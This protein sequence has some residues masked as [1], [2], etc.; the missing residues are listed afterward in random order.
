MADH[1][2]HLD[3]S[4]PW[5]RWY[6]TA[7]WQAL[8]RACYL[9]DNYTCRRTGELLI[10][11]APAPNSPVANH[12]EP[13]HGDPVLFWDPDNIETVSKRVHDG[14][15]QRQEKSGVIIGSDADGRPVDPQHPWNR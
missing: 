15:V 4:Q 5:R 10:G 1:H 9:R 3:Q 12:I 8:A 14:Q 7:R 6:K 13:H 11:K 2:R